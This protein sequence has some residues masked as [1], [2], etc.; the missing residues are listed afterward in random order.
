MHYLRILR[1]AFRNAFSHLLIYR[2][3]FFFDLFGGLA[4]SIVMLGIIELIYHH[5]PSFNGWQKG[6]IALLYISLELSALIS[7]CLAKN[8]E[9]LE[10]HIR[11]GTF[12]TII[13]KPADSQFLS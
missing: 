11:T 2:E 5:T 9:Y 7:T 12:D 10:Q 8:I 4:W 1:Q 6:E 3:N 13:S